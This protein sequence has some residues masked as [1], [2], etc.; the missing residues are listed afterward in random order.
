MAT[1]TRDQ[2]LKT[3]VE[4]FN[5]RRALSQGRRRGRLRGD[6]YCCRSSDEH[7]GLLRQ[8]T[9]NA[10]DGSVAEQLKSAA[11]AEELRCALLN[12]REAK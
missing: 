6:W 8:L 1:D 3:G 4:S 2:V 7:L 11:T 9:R 10:D 5:F 12:G